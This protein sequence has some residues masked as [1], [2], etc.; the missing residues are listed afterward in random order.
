MQ[1]T[2]HIRSTTILSVRRGQELALGGDGQVTL[3]ETMIKQKA[4]KV[5]RLQKQ[6][7]DQLRYDVLIG[8]AGGSAD[9]VT[10]F[11]RLEE[12]LETANGDLRRAAVDLANDWRSDRSLRQLDAFMATADASHS[13]LVSGKGDLLEPDDGILAIGSGSPMALA[14][15]RALLAHTELSATKIVEESLRIASQICI[16]TNSQIHVET[17]RLT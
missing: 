1:R 13:F 7:R 10:L 9:A 6:D 8:I 12:K 11:S 15:A 3:G 14:A 2:Q 4:R 16:Y 17:I 5:Q